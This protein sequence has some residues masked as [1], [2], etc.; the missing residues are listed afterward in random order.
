MQTTAGN[1]SVYNMYGM[2]LRWGP[3]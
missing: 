1:A 3:G 2:C